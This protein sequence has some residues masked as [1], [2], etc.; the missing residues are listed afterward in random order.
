MGKSLYSVMLM[1]EVVREIDRLCLKQ[2][3]NR[4]NL[5]N[6]ILAEYVS[7]T[8]P[9]MRINSIFRDIEELTN[10]IPTGLAAFVT[11]HQSTM[12]LKSILEYRYRPT[13]KYDVELYSVEKNDSIGRLSV[14][15][16]TQSQLLMEK[17]AE[18]FNLWCYLEQNIGKRNAEYAFVNGKFIRSLSLS[19][20]KSYTSKEVADAIS[21]YVRLLDECIKGYLTGTLDEKGI[22]LKIKAHTVKEV[23]I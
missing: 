10:Q 15:F 18:F 3:T 20:G 8:T 14:G 11:P 17:I 16:R 4:S 22:A 7:Y 6:Q 9:Q 1:D 21:S 12:S 23:L 19:A 2:N 5:I 13:V